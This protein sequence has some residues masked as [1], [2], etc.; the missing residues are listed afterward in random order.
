MVIG[1]LILIFLA[2]FIGPDNLMYLILGL[3]KLALWIGLIGAVIL[4][5]ASFA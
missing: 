5:L 4:I 1:L 3:L 2:I